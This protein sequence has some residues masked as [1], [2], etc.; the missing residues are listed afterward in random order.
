MILS[1][2]CLCHWA[3]LITQT[4]S[5]NLTTITKQTQKQSL[6]V[7]V[8]HFS[9]HIATV[10]TLYCTYTKLGSIRHPS[11]CISCLN[12]LLFYL[13]RSYFVFFSTIAVVMSISPHN[14]KSDKPPLKA[15]C[16]SRE[17]LHFNKHVLAMLAFTLF[18]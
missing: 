9:G 4:Q 6:S 10:V 8:T 13:N 17:L 3:A 12:G 7:T 5:F 14:S 15:L 2:L 16:T 1:L 11:H 18:R